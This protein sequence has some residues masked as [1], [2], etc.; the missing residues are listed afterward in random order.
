MV[1]FKIIFFLLFSFKLYSQE[2]TSEE[3]SYFNF[4]DLDNNQ[5]LSYKEINQ[6]ILLVFKLIDK[7]QDDKIS[8][9]EVKDLKKIINS[10]K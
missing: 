4:L 10:I 6:V 5:N 2:L 1:L 7:N 8:K 9:D 3:K